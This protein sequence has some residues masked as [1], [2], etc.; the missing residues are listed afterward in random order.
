MFL[1]LA[2]SVVVFLTALPAQ[3]SD[4][5]AIRDKAAF[6]SLVEGRDLQIGVYNLTLNL[7]ADGEIRGSALGWD[8]TGSWDWKDG[9][10]CR[11]M[12]WS[13]ME[14]PYNCQLVETRDGEVIRFTVDKGTGDS[15]SF[16]L[17]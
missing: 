13:G 1:R 11:Q 14:I 2:L 6:L 4:F 8:I 5:S 16:K 12:D 17:R 3:A 9:Y 10:F 15:A 7:L